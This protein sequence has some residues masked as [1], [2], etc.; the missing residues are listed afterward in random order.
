MKKL[1]VYV[2]GVKLNG[3]PQWQVQQSLHKVQSSP[4]M[5][6][7]YLSEHEVQIPDEVFTAP[8]IDLKYLKSLNEQKQSI[9]ERY[10]FDM[11]AINQQIEEF[12]NK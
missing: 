12:K 4:Q 8:E 10:D 3:Y 9:Q 6:A 1:I 7:V 5:K 2:Y 11:D